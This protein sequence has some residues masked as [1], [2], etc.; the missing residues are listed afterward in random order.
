[1]KWEYKTLKFGTKGI[2]GGKVDESALDKAL[3]EIGRQ[4][5]ELV[6]MLATSQAQG[7]SR[8]LIAVFKRQD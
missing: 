1:M 3:N 8:D 4:G 6:S 7:Q 5:W 2:F